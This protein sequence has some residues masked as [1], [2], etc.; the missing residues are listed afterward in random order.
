MTPKF[1]YKPFFKD[2]IYLFLE[3]GKRRKK[4]RERNI[5]VFLPLACPPPTGD[6]DY[7]PGMCLHWELNQQP[8]ASQLGAWSTEPPQPGL[9]KPFKLASLPTPSPW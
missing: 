8:F 5:N 3:R 9:Y 1:F 2:Y 6:L 4:E 7:N